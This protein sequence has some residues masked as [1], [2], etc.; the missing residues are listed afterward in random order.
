MA[1]LGQRQQVRAI[2]R[3]VFLDEAGAGKGMD[4]VCAPYFGRTVE[5][6]Q[7]LVVTSFSLCDYTR[8]VKTRVLSQRS[9][10]TYSFQGI[11]SIMA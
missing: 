2:L 7:A 4:A 5:A 6:R 10:T 9:A 3:A 8:T 1:E 11:G